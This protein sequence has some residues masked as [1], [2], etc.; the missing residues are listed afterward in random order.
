MRRWVGAVL[1]CGT[2]AGIVAAAPIGGEPVAGVEITIERGGARVASTVTDNGGSFRFSGLPAGAYTLRIVHR[3]LAARRE[4]GSGIA[5]GRRQ[6]Q[7]LLTREAGSGQ[8]T[9][10][11]QKLA[12][13]EADTGGNGGQT[14]KVSK[15]DALTFKYAV[16]I[17]GGPGDTRITQIP[18]TTTARSTDWSHAVAVQ[19]GESGKLEGTVTRD[20]DHSSVAPR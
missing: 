12:A 2:A 8:A 7:P 4:A 20:P 17:G 1:I 15:V 11:R 5:T 9:G 13:A 18:T 6:Y 14:T 19:V 3:D 10:Q 16:R